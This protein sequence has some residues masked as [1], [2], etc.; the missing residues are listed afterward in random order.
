MNT[1]YFEDLNVGDTATYSRTIQQADIAA[2]AELSGDHNP[3]HQDAAYAATTPFKGCIAHGMLGASYISTVLG[4]GLPGPGSIFMGL[5]IRFRAPV[6]P[7]DTVDAQVTITELR[8][9][10]AIATL[11]AVCRVGET[12]VITGTAVMKVPRRPAAA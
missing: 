8:A 3:I 7:G 2:F 6:R 5:D 1:R 12:E 10:K 4:T 9:D 11:A